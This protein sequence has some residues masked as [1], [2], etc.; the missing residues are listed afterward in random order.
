LKVTFNPATQKRL[1]NQLLRQRS[2]K[3]L[4]QEQQEL[5]RGICDRFKELREELISEEQNKLEERL[6]QPKQFLQ[7]VLGKRDREEPDTSQ[8]ATKRQQLEIPDKP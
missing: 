8:P 4:T 1:V 2:N 5:V 6:K 7:T 3:N